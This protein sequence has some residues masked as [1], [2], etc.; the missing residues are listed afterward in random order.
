M[1]YYEYDLNGVRARLAHFD[2]NR[3][4]AHAILTCP[5]NRQDAARTLAALDEAAEKIAGLLDM[6]PVF[7]RYLLSDAT[8]Q[9]HLLK[10]QPICARSIIQQSPLDGS[11]AALL[12]IYNR[13]SDFTDCGLG[14][15]MDS[16][17]RI[18]AGDNDSIIPADSRTMTIDYLDTLAARL[19]KSGASLEGHCIRTWF[20]V[21]DVD[22]NYA[23]VVSGRN[24]VFDRSGL[25]AD[26]HFISST[27]IAGQAPDPTRIVAFNAFA[28]TRI[29]ASQIKFLYGKTHLNPTYEYGVAFERGT[30]VDY[31]DRRHVY[32]SGTASIDNKGNIV[33]EG[34]IVAQTTRMLENIEVLLSEASCGW[35]D[36]AHMIVY[37]RDIADYSTVA[38]IIVSRFPDIP[39]VIVLAPVCRP[40]W[41][42]ETEC[43]AVKQ[44]SNP[45]YESF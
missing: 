24:E 4:E 11:K 20:F 44:V 39:T 29:D 14:M 30:A 28:D 41:L 38:G 26:S 19:E 13:Q 3:G 8:N 32:I 5:G 7:M 17:G 35:S 6:Q 42:I 36:V 2:V 10:Q 1:K 25:T 15:W 27:G 9:A 16:R 23:G 12:V 21:R 34:D 33:A 22:N 40:G 37:L 18:W 31:A 45:S 43:M